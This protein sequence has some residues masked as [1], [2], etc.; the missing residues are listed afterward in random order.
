MAIGLGEVYT[1][2]ELR[3]IGS[4]EDAVRMAEEHRRQKIAG[5]TGFVVSRSGV[6]IHFG[7]PQGHGDFVEDAVRISTGED[8]GRYRRLRKVP[9]RAEA[10][11]QRRSAGPTPVA[12]ASSFILVARRAMVACQMPA[13]N[14]VARRV[15]PPAASHL[16]L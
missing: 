1:G 16:Y 4:V 13:G 6:F 7:G 2:L 11:L 3:T 9:R 10:R 15:P 5:A 14:L 8:R 12:F